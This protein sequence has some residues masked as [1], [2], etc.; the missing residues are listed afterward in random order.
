MAGIARALRRYKSAQVATVWSWLSSM[1]MSLARREAQAEL[2]HRLGGIDDG[3]VGAARCPRRP[4][5]RNHQEFAPT[6]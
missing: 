1:A 4:A 2:G 5:P 3:R 6:P